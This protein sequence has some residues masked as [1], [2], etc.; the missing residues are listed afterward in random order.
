VV[1]EL[2]DVLTIPT[3]VVRVDSNTVQTY[4]NRQVGEGVE[5]VDAELGVRYEGVAQVLDGL[6]EGDVIVWVES[7]IFELQHP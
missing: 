6:S 2:T 7:T 5:R 3:W 4:V 1:E